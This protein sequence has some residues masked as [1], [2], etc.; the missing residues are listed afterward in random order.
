MLRGIQRQAGR[1]APR[2]APRPL[3]SPRLR[4]VLAA[5]VV[6][7]AALT[8]ALGMLFAGQAHPGQVDATV[9]RWIVSGLAT[10]RGLLDLLADLGEPVSV[11]VL[12]AAL[13]LACAVVR[14]WRGCLLAAAAVPAASA[15]TELLLKPATGRTINGLLSYP[16]GHATAMFAL[17]TI[18][19]ILLAS[20]PRRVVP[21]ATR[22]ALSLA[23]YV[24][25]A[26]VS[27]AMVGLGAHYF[28]DTLGGAA[29]GTA[30]PLIVAFV[31][32][33]AAPAVTGGRPP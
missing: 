21:P 17:A 31:I 29:V 20:P 12:T 26:A 22:L 1:A 2:A 27:V 15:L 19:A 33:L 9:D 32:D 23:A 6:A 25:A 13:V 24:V 5:L 18:C 4:P 7:C 16:S 3:L 14:R 10:H 8:P 11:T 30:V 28:T